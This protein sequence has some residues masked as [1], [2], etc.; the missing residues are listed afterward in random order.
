MESLQKLKQTLTYM[1]EAHQQLLRLAEEKRTILVEGKAPELQTIISKE[2]K[3]TDLIQKLEA[4]REAVLKAVLV[5][6]GLVNQSLTIDQFI[7]TIDQP[8]EKQFL[9]KTIGQLRKLV[10]ELIQLNKSNQELIKMA[11]SYIQ[12]SMNIIMPKEPS[13]G[14]GNKSHV[15]SAKLLDAKI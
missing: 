8:L 1:V 7:Q 3:Y 4:Q 12:Y 5:E 2:S 13:I 10:N 11:L 9:A 6:K 15:R 14:Y